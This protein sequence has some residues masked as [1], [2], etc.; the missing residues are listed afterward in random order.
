[1]GAVAIFPHA[2]RTVDNLFIP[3]SDGCRLSA[4]LWLPE[5]AE[6]F[7]VPAIL[8]YLPYRKNDRTAR[9]D[10]RRHPYFAG[11]GYAAIRV[12]MRGSGESDG[13]LLDEYLRAG[14]GRRP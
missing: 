9:G 10:A 2:V 8:E 12:D 6:T 14:A 4:R 3:L 13:L 7:P 1:M 5:D 11:H